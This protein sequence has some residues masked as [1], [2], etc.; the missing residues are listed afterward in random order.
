MTLLERTNPAIIKTLTEVNKDYPTTL[1]QILGELSS[2]STLH[3]LQYG[4]AVRI[5]M[6]CKLDLNN[7]YSQFYES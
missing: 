4:T 3:E 6:D 2:V 7:L 5:A 1:S